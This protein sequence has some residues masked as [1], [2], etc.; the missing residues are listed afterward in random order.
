MANGRIPVPILL[1][2]SVRARCDESYLRHWTVLHCFFSI[3]LFFCLNEL[4]LFNC[5]QR[6]RLRRPAATTP[7]KNRPMVRWK[8]LQVAVEPLPVL[9]HSRTIPLVHLQLPWRVNPRSF[10]ALH[11]RSRQL[12]KPAYRL[13]RSKRSV[14]RRIHTAC[15]CL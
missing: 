12:S 8:R 2:T 15:T 4:D 14:N 6:T 9:Y 11:H 1:Q 5:L 3:Y 10:I 13:R 7:R